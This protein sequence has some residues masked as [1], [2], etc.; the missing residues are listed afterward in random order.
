M[1][2]NDEIRS[3]LIFTTHDTNLLDKALFNE[4]EIWFLEKDKE[5]AS[6][7]SSL[8]DYKQNKEFNSGDDDLDETK[9]WLNGSKTHLWL[10]G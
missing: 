7:I 8:A 10:G 1:I 5:G 9:R 6:H 3:Q 2:V 4:N